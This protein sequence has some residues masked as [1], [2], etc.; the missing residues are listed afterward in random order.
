MKFGIYEDFGVKTCGGFPGSEFYMQLDAKTFA[1]WGVD[2]LKFDG[3]YSD[4]SDIPSGNNANVSF[5]KSQGLFIFH[6]YIV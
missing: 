6:N 5:K 4:T 3:C 2:L 1:D